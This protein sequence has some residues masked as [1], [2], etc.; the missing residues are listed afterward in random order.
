MSGEGASQECQVR[1]SYKSPTRVSRKSVLQEGQASSVKEKCLTRLSSRGAP[2]EC[3]V[4]VS[5]KGAKYEVSS[6]SVSQKRRRRVFY[7]SVKSEC[8]T[9]VSSKSV[10]QKCQ[11]RVSYK[12]VK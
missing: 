3:H 12:S 8:P 2:P 5:Y 9:E 1:L 4:R 11:V 10:L 7:K 6:E